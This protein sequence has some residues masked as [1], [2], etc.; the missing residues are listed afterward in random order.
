MIA[1]QLA[2]SLALGGAYALMALGFGLIFGVLDLIHWSYGDVMI[3]GAYVA[4][5]FL[6]GSTHSFFLLLTGVVVATTLVGVVVERLNFHALREKPHMVI[7][8]ASLG[9]AMVI[10]NAI[11]ILWGPARRRFLVDVPL[12]PLKVLGITLSGSRVLSIVLSVVVMVGL[13]FL[14][15]RTR[16]GMAIRATILDRDA[17]ILMGINRRF[18]MVSTFAL[19]S[20]LSG[21]AMLLLGAMY[22]VVFPLE[23]NF[24]GLMVFAAVII[25]GL[26]SIPGA[27]VGGIIIGFSQTLS[28]AFISVTYKDAITMSLLAL[29]LILKPSGIFGKPQEENF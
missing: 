29:A 27:M 1:Q 13:D 21:V 6:S 28:A 11:L 18:I 8:I 12:P 5:T 7:L 20:A 17:A 19:G 3:A 23:G 9:V 2:N 22:G 16:L 4:L 26:G 24:I 14:L 15:R 10:Q 25:G